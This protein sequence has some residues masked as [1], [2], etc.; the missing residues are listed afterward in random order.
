MLQAFEHWF[1]TLSFY[2]DSYK[3]VEAPYLGMEHQSSVTYGNG[4]KNGYRGRDLSAT[5]W[6]L[7]L[8]LLL[9]LSLDTN[10]FANNITYKDMRICGFMRV[11]KLF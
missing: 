5:G 7:S 10:G 1:W 11:Y 4:F 8:I 2:E 3:L 6:G 9:F